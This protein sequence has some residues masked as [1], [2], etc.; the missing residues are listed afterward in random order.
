MAEAAILNYGDV[1][2]EK[3]TSSWT[4]II[5]NEFLVYNF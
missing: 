3:Y 2:L 4:I 1:D 5:R